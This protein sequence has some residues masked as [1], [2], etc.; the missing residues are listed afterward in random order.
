[1]CLEKIK[2]SKWHVAYSHKNPSPD[3]DGQLLYMRQDG[4]IKAIMRI[5]PAPLREHAKANVRLPRANS[6]SEIGR[7]HV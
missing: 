1:M 2:V 5:A 3:I 6:P 4:A 7:A